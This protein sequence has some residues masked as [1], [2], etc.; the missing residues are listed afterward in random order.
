LA[1]RYYEGGVGDFSEGWNKLS[2]NSDGRRGARGENCT[3]LI[4]FFF[5]KKFSSWGGKEP[6]YLK[7][8]SSEEGANNI[9][10]TRERMRCRE[11]SDFHK[12]GKLVSNSA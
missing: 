4:G 11:G 9:N 5:K 6:V 8:R 7:K 2:I 12:G 3:L 1:K 10:M